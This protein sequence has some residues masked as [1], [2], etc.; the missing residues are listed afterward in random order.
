RP[1]PWLGPPR[2][3][4]I[5]AAWLFRMRDWCNLTV[6]PLR[7]SAIPPPRELKSLPAVLPSTVALVMSTF[8]GELPTAWMLIPPPLEPRLPVEAVL[9]E[10]V[11]LFNV[12]WAGIWKVLPS[13]TAKPPP[14]PLSLLLAT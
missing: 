3:V 1:P 14:S 7:L 4:L 9:P 6:P 13:A 8:K 11:T 5:L 12:N 2:K 10:T